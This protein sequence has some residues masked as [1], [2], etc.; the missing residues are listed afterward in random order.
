MI[1]REV[2]K[3]GYQ[4]SGCAQYIQETKL[5]KHMVISGLNFPTKSLFILGENFPD[6]F[7]VHSR[8]ARVLF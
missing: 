7:F 8:E 5:P 6:P 3:R 2:P 4:L 1:M